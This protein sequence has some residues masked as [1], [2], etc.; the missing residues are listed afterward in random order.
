MR[1]VHS[2]TKIFL[3]DF[4]G[5]SHASPCPEVLRASKTGIRYYPPSMVVQSNTQLICA[6]LIHFAE[7]ANGILTSSY[8]TD[9][10]SLVRVKGC[11]RLGLGQRGRNKA[12]PSGVPYWIHG[13][14]M[15]LAS[16]KGKVSRDFRV[17]GP[18]SRTVIRTLSGVIP[19]D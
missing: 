19:S 1:F 10:V 6:I 18:R 5:Q 7:I 13:I 16:R 12:T 14:C 11:M 2:T 15:P 3:P 4:G 8:K 17:G 9:I